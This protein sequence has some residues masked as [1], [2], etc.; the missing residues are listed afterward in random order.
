MKAFK[1]KLL[2]TAIFSATALSANATSIT[3]LDGTFNNFGGFDWASNGSAWIQGYD[4]VSGG[5]GRI[6]ETDTFTLTY[7]AN[8][9]EV[10]DINGAGINLGGLNVDYE[11]TVYATITEQIT[12]ITD[13]CN[14]VQIDVLSGNWDIYYDTNPSTFFSNTAGTGVTE[15]DILLSGTFFSSL[16]PGGSQSVVSTQGTNN[17][18]DNSI[19]AALR[20]EVTF[21][22]NTYINPELTN[23]TAVSTLQFGN[24]TTAWT[25]PDTIDGVNPGPDTNSDFIGQADANQSFS[26]AVTVPEPGSLALLGLGLGLLGFNRTRK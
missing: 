8:A 10:Q 22:N 23:S 21:T 25:R 2:A 19:L 9:I 16:N 18:G 7:I 4:I 24:L 26:R 5:S 13:N 3:N 1:I 20:G 12:C 11:Y 17:P 15:G 14:F 6:G